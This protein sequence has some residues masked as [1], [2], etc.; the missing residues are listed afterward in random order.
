MKL[1]IAN[2]KAYMNKAQVMAWLEEFL[3][4]YNKNSLESKLSQSNTCIV[5]CPPTPL[6][7]LVQEFT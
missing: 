1:L 5:I 6:I 2:W 3:D 7:P 4:L